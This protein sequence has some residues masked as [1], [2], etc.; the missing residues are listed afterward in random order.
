MKTIEELLAPVSDELPCGE[1]LDESLEFDTLRAAFDDDFALDTGM[2]TLADGEKRLSP[3]NWSET[4]DNIEKLCGQTKDLFLAVSYARCGIVRGDPDIVDQ[5][6]QFAARLLEEQWDTV[7]PLVDDPGGRLRGPLFEDLARRGAF[8]M[9]FLGMPLVLGN[10]GSIKSEQLIDV[11]ENGG[12]SDSYP[13]VRGILDQLE[14]EARAAIAAQLASMLDSLARIEAVLRER[15]VSGRPD[16]STLRDSIGLVEEAYLAL[17]GL[18]VPEAD[19]ESGDG[20]DGAD[21]AESVGTSGP[22]FGGAV[23]SRD[24]VMKALNAIEQY[25]ARAEPGHPV[26]LAMGRMRSWVNKDFMG[27][28]EDIA[29]RSL[30]DVK[31]VLLERSDVE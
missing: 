16:F 18:A 11:H 27:I 6:L 7:H 14:D 19:G 26:R 4:F 5:G 9:P 13:A 1:D 21:E 3:V 28:L 25:Y 23:K 22:G 15:N 8:A 20:D 31:S 17:A 30:D 12:T 2:A 24:D 10:R 29:P